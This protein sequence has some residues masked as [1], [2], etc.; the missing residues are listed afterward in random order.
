VAI[1]HYAAIP[2][3]GGEEPMA[4]TARRYGSR[5]I[6]RLSAL[7]PILPGLALT[8]AI[9][10][11][12]T[13]LGR[14]LPIVGGAVLAILLGISIRLLIGLPKTYVPGVRFAG[15]R[16]LQ[17][18]IVLLGAGLSLRQVWTT[19]VH[20]LVVLLGTLLIG[21][22]VML[23]LG[24]LLGVDRTLT[25]LIS[26]GT[27]ICGASAI[28]A[29]APILEADEA[30]ISYAI[31]TVFLF[32]IT[33]VLLFPPLG[34]LLGLSQQGFG[35]WAGTAVNDTSSV[36]ATGYSFGAAAGT[37]AVI[38]KLSRTVLI[39]PVSLLFAA[40]V[41]REQ[42]AHAAPT[43]RPAR[44]GVPLFILFFLGTGALNTLGLL[45]SIGPRVLPSV[46][47]FLI[48]TALAG[49]G[50]SADARTMARSGARPVLLGLLGWICLAVTSLALQR[51]GGLI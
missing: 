12:A 17:W 7:P 42:R 29:L 10:I 11:V 37:T 40:V 34:H 4:A 45:G 31:A 15:K 27:G 25:R 36:V 50:L 43:A 21:L 33:A 24:R 44:V 47:Q 18:A 13:I 1:K 23:L 38:V 41:A 3:R 35:L 28:G 2:M 16:L 22:P 5:L 6:R 26:V 8:I 30:A 49:V 20:S 39:V 51:A 46:G 14:F 19:G 32:N 9:A 48:V